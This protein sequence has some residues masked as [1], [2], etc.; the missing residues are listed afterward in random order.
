MCRLLRFTGRPRHSPTPGAGAGRRGGRASTAGRRGLSQ[1]HVGGGRGGD[2]AAGLDPR[3]WSGGSRGSDGIRARG[4]GDTARVYP[5]TMSDAGDEKPP[6]PLLGT[7]RSLGGHL[8]RVGRGRGRD[9][10]QA[11]RRS[12]CRAWDEGAPPLPSG[13]T[14]AGFRLFGFLFA[15]AWLVDS[16]LLA[17]RRF[18]ALRQFLR[19]F[20]SAP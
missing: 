15:V 16:R 6:G 1:A 5:D 8:L 10:G 4:G 3:P 2:S 19:S 11:R 18:L 12:L 17:L 9:R 14:R 20:H 7:R 13:R